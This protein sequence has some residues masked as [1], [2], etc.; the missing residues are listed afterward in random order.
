MSGFHDVEFPLSLA[1]GARGGPQR[2]TQITPLSNG[3]EQR[4]TSHADSKRRYNA[5]AGI[6]S[7]DDL[8]RLIAFF[9]ARR[10][11]LYSFRFKDPMDFKSC[12]P[13]HSIQA[14]DQPLGVGDGASLRFQLSK[15]YSDV[16]GVYV[17]KITKP[18]SASVQVAVNGVL[19]TV[20]VDVTSGLVTFQTPPVLGAIITAGFE[21]HVP[22]RFDVDALELTLEA[23]GAGEAANIPLI[24]VG[25]YASV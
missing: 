24:E 9:E 14:S 7:L 13:S 20:S 6:K 5:G 2:I 19:E 17:R 15:T 1:F 8:H 12:L 4:N 16:S 25:D 3:S 10:G 23:F 22:V 21:F 18:I 11:Q